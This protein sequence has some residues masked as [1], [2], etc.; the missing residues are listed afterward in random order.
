MEKIE[1]EFIEYNQHSI[2][3]L[4]NLYEALHFIYPQ[5]RERLDPVFNII[6]ENWTKA[7]HANYPLFWVGTLAGNEKNIASTCTCWQYLNKG[8]LGQ[9]LASNHPVGSRLIFLNMLNRVIENQ[10]IDSIDSYQIYYR[11]QN[12]Y[13]ARMFE[14]LSMRVGKELSQIVSYTYCEVPFV[15]EFK[16]EELEII[17]VQE[18]NRQM[19]LNF[20]QAERGEVYIKVQELDSVDINLEN[21][22]KKFAVHGLQRKRS[23]FMAISNNDGKVQG[24]IIFNQSSLG[25]NFSFL[26]NS[27]ELILN[28]TGDKYYLQVAGL[29]LAKATNFFPHFP[30]KYL[31]ILIDPVNC[32]IIEQLKGKVIRDYN[33]FIILRG[34][35]EGWYAYVDN[36]TRAIYQR[37][38]DHSYERTVSN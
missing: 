10:V 30:L 25:L 26:E 9:H 12:K 32:Q 38:I 15:K 29:L 2:E 34:G 21:L 4:L 28:K 11:P 18:A 13:S 31:P 8:M 14:P 17:E 24:A 19:F 6:K 35:Y 7:L 3:K 27:S 37:F 23:V 1:N 36:L 22:N 33:L 5:K 16:A 20:L